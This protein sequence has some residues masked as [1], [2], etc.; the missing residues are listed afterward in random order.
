MVNANNCYYL[1]W[2]WYSEVQLLSATKLYNEVLIITIAKRESLC[3][4]HSKD[5]K[6]HAVLLTQLAQTN[7]SRQLVVHPPVSQWHNYCMLLMRT[8]TYRSTGGLHSRTTDGHGQIQ[9]DSV[10]TG[11]SRAFADASSR[12]RTEAKAS[13]PCERCVAPLRR[14]RRQGQRQ[15]AV[16]GFLVLRSLA[17]RS[18]LALAAPLFGP[19]LTCCLAMLVVENVDLSSVFQKS[20]KLIE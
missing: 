4:L 10:A 8:D 2:K 3:L 13:F 14:I 20:I 5:K 15:G 6:H 18:A 7:P 11:V 9:I 12:G 16:A 17:V 19:E 1:I